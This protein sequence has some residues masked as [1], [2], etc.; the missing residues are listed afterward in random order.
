MSEATGRPA[1]RSRA[2]SAGRS[3]PVGRDEHSTPADAAS[4]PLGEEAT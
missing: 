4:E 2:R 1:A 3:G